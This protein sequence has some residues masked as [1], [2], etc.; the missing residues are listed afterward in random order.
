MSERWGLR[1]DERVAGS[2]VRY[3]AVAVAAVYVAGAWLFVP[4][5]IA[6]AAPAVA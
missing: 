4:N 1:E 6:V 2:A 3:T 5:W